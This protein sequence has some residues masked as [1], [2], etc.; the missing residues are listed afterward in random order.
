[1]DERN[2]TCSQTTIRFHFSGQPTLT[3]AT[4][5]FVRKEYYVV[6]VVPQ[7]NSASPRLAQLPSFGE[8]QTTGPELTAQ[9]SKMPPCICQSCII[10]GMTFSGSMAI[11]DFFSQS[12][13]SA[14]S[15]L[16]EFRLLDL[17]VQKHPVFRVPPICFP[18]RQCCCH[19]CSLWSTLCNC[20]SSSLTLRLTRNAW[21]PGRVIVVFAVAIS[22]QPLLTRICSVRR[23]NRGAWF[24]QV[25]QPGYAFY[26]SVS[27]IQAWKT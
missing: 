13:C 27:Q 23:V 3:N 14:V 4:N 15:H 18:S 1:M 12:Q 17:V 25:S 5:A 16:T 20:L 26:R 19:A 2:I 8:N 6:H 21:V 7:D 24:Y 11:T 10:S 9:L 22:V